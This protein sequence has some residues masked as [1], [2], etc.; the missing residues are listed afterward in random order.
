MFFP[1]MSPTFGILGLIFPL[2]MFFLIFRILRGIFRSSHR[3]IE[4]RMRG[5][6]FPEPDPEFSTITRYPAI[7]PPTSEG[8]IFR[9]ADEMKGR[10]TLSDIVIA[11]NLSLKEAER[12]IDSMVDGTHVTMEVKDNGRV[13]YE[14]PEI[15]AR[16]ENQGP[17]A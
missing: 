8:E 7:Q 4:S 3:N 14:F 17:D 1:F 2:M 16:Y 15:I 6:S 12:V 13:V 9:L 5:L 11:T 10:L